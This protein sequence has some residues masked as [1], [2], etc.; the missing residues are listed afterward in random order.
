MTTHKNLTEFANKPGHFDK[1]LVR[2]P[3]LISDSKDVYLKNHGS[4]VFQSICNIEI[5]CKKGARFV[6]YHYWLQR[7]FTTES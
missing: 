2:H 6:D 1:T 5:E 7:N 4:T 3:I